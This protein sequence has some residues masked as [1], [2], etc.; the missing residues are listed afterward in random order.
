MNKQ[1]HLWYDKEGDFLE[2]R[3][4]V[5]GKGIFL[6]VGNECFE[7]VDKKTGKVVGFAIFNFNKRFQKQHQELNLPVEMQLKALEA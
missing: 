4:G 3:T 6:P 7:R 1:L 5:T 2:F